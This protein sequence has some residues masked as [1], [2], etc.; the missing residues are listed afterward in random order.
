MSAKDEEETFVE[1]RAITGFVKDEIIT[2]RLQLDRECIDKLNCS[3]T[4]TCENG[5]CAEAYEPPEELPLY[6]RSDAGTQDADPSNPKMDARAGADDANVD[7][8]AHIALDAGGA[9]G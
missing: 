3:D 5:N 1:A 6:T 9:E 8:D 7:G 4:E 2:L